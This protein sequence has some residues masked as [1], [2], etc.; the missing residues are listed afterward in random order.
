[1]K[2][3]MFR[4]VAAAVVL[5]LF[6][7][8]SESRPWHALT[9][10]RSMAASETESEGLAI[11][12]ASGLCVCIFDF[13]ETL[14]VWKDGYG[15]SPAADGGAIVNKCRELGYEIAIASANC[16]TEKLQKV[17]PTV[18]GVFEPSFFETM[19][20]QNCDHWKTHQLNKIL[21]YFGTQPEC[22]MFFDDQG[23]NLHKHAANVGVNGRHVHGDTGVTW[24]DF[25]FAKSEM[26]SRCN[27]GY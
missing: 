5:L 10:Y 9:H 26:E 15:D 11:A 8:G 6:A 23:H 4:V 16:N 13:D 1:M 7:P 25:W 20:F 19:A 21:N 14:R 24:D 12:K 18:N 3:C 27:C 17:L 2:S 22:A